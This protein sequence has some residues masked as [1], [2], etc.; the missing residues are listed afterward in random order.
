MCFP[1]TRRRFLLKRLLSRLTP[2]SQEIRFGHGIQELRGLWGSSVDLAPILTVAGCCASTTIVVLQLGF[3]TA[4]QGH[5]PSGMP[6]W[7]VHYSGLGA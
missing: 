4:T 6:S 1:F 5:V 7:E 2:S 3:G